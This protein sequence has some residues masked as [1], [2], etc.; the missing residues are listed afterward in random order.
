[1]GTSATITFPVTQGSALLLRID[2]MYWDDGYDSS[3]AYTQPGIL[4]DVSWALGEKAP[5]ILYR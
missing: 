4:V 5:T 2:R 1:M 3:G